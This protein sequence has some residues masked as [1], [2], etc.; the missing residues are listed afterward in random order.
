MILII[1]F[2]RKNMNLYEAVLFDMDGLMFDTERLAKKGL[3][4]AAAE[5]GLVPDMDLFIGITGCSGSD[6]QLRLLSY[7]GS[8]ERYS[9]LMR[10]EEEK[11]ALWVR[12]GGTPLKP[13]LKE[14]LSLLKKKKVR[15]AVVSCS[16]RVR[17]MPCMEHS[18]LG[19]A[20]DLIITGEEVTNGKP[21]PDAYL[22][23]AAK[24]GVAPDE[25]LVLEDS[26]NGGN[27][28]LAAGMDVALIPDLIM[29]TEAEKERFTYVKSS[30]F[31]V[32]PLFE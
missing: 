12:E 16:H 3:Y 7:C 10:L 17:V 23:A 26:V 1:L 11:V 19:E 4:E 20:F 27:A 25:C 32:I 30:L 15:C 6:V 13:G 22:I 18:G 21:A 31:D 2:S 14:L 24:L 28:G 9:E 5:L 29:P 8:E